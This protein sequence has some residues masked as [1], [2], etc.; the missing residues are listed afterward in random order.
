M[1]PSS[2]PRKY[3]GTLDFDWGDLP[4]LDEPARELAGGMELP[5]PEGQT[6][7]GYPKG[8]ISFSLD[9]GVE[10]LGTEEDGTKRRVNIPVPKRTTTTAAT[11]GAPAPATVEQQKKEETEETGAVNGDATESETA[12]E[13]PTESIS[14]PDP[15]EKLAALETPTPTTVATAAGCL[16]SYSYEY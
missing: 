7:P 3:G 10:L 11:N 12:D 14:T 4:L 9:K 5:P 1:E 8:P 16:I 6:R 2:I 13:R 15:D